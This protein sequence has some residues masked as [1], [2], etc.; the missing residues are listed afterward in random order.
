MALTVSYVV[1]KVFFGSFSTSFRRPGLVRFYPNCGAIADALALRICANAGLMQRKQP[2]RK[3]SAS[4]LT[5]L[6]CQTLARSRCYSNGYA[7]DADRESGL[8]PGAGRCPQPLLRSTFAFHSPTSDQ[9]R[10]TSTG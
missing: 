8:V 5:H 1:R 9:H 4:R 3:I 7:R 2:T 10:L 6:R